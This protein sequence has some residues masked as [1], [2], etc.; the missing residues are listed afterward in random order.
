MTGVPFTVLARFLK[1]GDMT[2]RNL[3]LV[4]A[5]LRGRE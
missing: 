1:G 2:G 3:D 5:F 4:E